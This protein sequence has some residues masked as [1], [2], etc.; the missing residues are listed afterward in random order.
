Q[1][2]RLSAAAATKLSVR[3]IPVFMRVSDIGDESSRG[4]RCN[5]CAGGGRASAG[6][7]FRTGPCLVAV[8][9]SAARQ[10]VWRELQ[11]DPVAHEDAD[12]ELRHLA[13]GVCQHGVAVLE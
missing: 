3:T 5:G 7:G 8:G 9:D 13:G 11:R 4:R 12:L 1:L 2:P 10:V 6:S